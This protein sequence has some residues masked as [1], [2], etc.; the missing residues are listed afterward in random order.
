M[1]V[2]LPLLA[3]RFGQAFRT[4]VLTSEIQDDD[5]GAR[6]E[7]ALKCFFATCVMR[8]LASP[9]DHPTQVFTQVQLSATNES[10]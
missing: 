1:K 4:H 8:K 3:T 7:T 6:D 10:V 9:F 5:I 2:Y